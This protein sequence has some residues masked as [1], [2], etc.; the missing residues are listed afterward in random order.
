MTQQRITFE[1]VLEE[2]RVDFWLAPEADSAGYRLGLNSAEQRI[3]IRVLRVLA[4]LL[5]VITAAAGAGM[6]P[7]ERERREAQAGIGFALELENKAWARRDRGLYESLI[8]PHLSDDWE[9]AW[10]DY[11][12]AGAEVEPDFK[13]TLLYVRE[14][15]GFMQASVITEQPA[16]EW[17][18]T[19]PYREERFYRRVDRRWL[20]T[21]P[22]ASHWGEVRELHTEHLHFLYYELDAEAV[23]EAAPK[24]EKAFIGMYR[25][26]GLPDAPIE[27]QVITVVPHPIGRWSSTVPQL[28]VTSPLLAQIPMGQS[29]GE[30]LAYEVMGWFTYRAIRDAAPNSGVRY[31]YRWP[32][33]VWGLR[34]WL[35]DDLIEQPSPWH[36]EATKVLRDA[37][38]DFLPISLVDITDLR[39]NA[40]PSR[41]EVILRYLS[42]ESFMRFIV[43][44]YGR[45][46]VPALLYA[47]VRFSAWEDIIPPVYGDSVEEFEAA[48]NA[49]LIEEYGI[50]DVVR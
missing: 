11:W 42:A 10:R 32:I 29:D 9:E 13:A 18:Q 6:N 37:A 35:R 5:V 36:I 43:D 50:E 44:N 24:L 48:W 39:T 3:A 49:H 45:E 19:N 30:Y 17:W 40:R 21:V 4:L 20:R 28:E 38:P 16:F 47:L 8:D 46:R 33:L 7:G 26:L 15:G 25:T 1:W 23:K 2:G 22:P 27:K 41:E 12:R 31:L 34:G 14:T